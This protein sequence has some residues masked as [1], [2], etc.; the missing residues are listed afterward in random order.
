MPEEARLR[1]GITNGLL[2]VSVGCENPDD[3]IKD[4]K[5]QLDRAS[6][7]TLKPV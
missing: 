1:L 5:A 2:R 3:I 4:F 7:T 6:N